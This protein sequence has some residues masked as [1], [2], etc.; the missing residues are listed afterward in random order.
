MSTALEIA[1]VVQPLAGLADRLGAERIAFGQAELAADHLVLG[2]R[3]ADDVDPL[4]ID[5]RPL[6]DVEGQRRRCG[7]G[8]S[9]STRGLTSTKA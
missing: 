4:D 6:A 2:A 1:E 9:G 8:G 5:P 3:V 7:S